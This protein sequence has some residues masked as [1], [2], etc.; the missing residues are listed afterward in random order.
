MDYC[1]FGCNAKVQRPSVCNAMETLLVH[2]DAV[3]KFM[4]AMLAKY[5]EAGVERLQQ[6]NSIVKV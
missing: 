4:P 5:A 6:P 3:A 2:K 1:C